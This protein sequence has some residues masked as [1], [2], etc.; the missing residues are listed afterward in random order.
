M[1]TT[2][3]ILTGFAASTVLIPGVAAGAPVVYTAVGNDAADI[4]PTRDAFRVALGGGTVAGPNGSFGGVR[5]EINWDG[6]PAQFAAPN[7]L[8]PNFFN[9]NSPRGVVLSTP[10][11][12]FQVSAD[13]DDPGITPGQ[14]EFGNINPNNIPIFEP[15]SPDRLFTALDSTIT[16]VNFFVPGTTTPGFTNGFGVIFSDVDLAATTR[17]D[18]FDTSGNLLLSGFA[19]NMPGNEN[20]SFFGVHFN[21]GEQVGRVRITS[22]NTPLGAA[23][24][25]NASPQTIDLVVQD[26]WIYGEPLIP[27]PATATLMGLGAAMMLIRRRR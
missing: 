12:G 26:D 8:P 10:G 16:D 17:V 15:F 24:N 7:N 27:E 5:R 4:T 19:P 1:G 20:Y 13:P 25:E 18:Y 14:V 21:G 23:N 11:T 3:R 2:Y 22:G 6:T 9:T